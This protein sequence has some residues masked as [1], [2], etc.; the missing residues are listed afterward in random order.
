MQTLLGKGKTFTSGSGINHALLRSAVSTSL[1]AAASRSCSTQARAQLM[2]L[3]RVSA[4]ER[5]RDSKLKV[6]TWL[7]GFRDHV[8]V[9]E[10]LKKVDTEMELQSTAGGDHT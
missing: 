3:L 8:T 9:S 10:T 7:E 1:K 2:R 5:V 6:L 4:E